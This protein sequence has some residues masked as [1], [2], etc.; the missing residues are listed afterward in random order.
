MNTEFLFQGCEFTLN[1][2]LREA[3]VRGV[4]PRAC[5]DVLALSKTGGHQQI[6]AL[7][8]LY[9]PHHECPGAGP[10]CLSKRESHGCAL[11]PAV[12]V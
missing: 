5:K 8:V 7:L 10:T 2:I 1:G 9:H 12:S 4:E 3:K 11:A 6:G